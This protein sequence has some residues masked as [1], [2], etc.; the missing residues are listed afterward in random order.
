MAIVGKLKSEIENIIG[1]TYTETEVI[2]I[3]NECL[4][5][6]LVPVLRLETKS[7]TAI[8]DGD[9]TVS[10]P[11][12][13][14]KLVNVHMHNSDEYLREVY[15]NDDNSSGYKIFDSVLEVRQDAKKLPDLLTIW[16]YRYPAAIS[17]MTDTPDMPPQFHHALKYYFLGIKHD[18]PELQKFYLEKYMNMKTQI[19][20]A[21]RKRV[22]IGKSRRI[23]KTYW[24]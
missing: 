24:F 2:D 17:S 6:D 10:L 7:S 16:Y 20:E 14:Y 19:D 12:D 8:T 4:R 23:K 5:E 21:S 11:D 1:E 13:L 9:T 15:L 3:F 22:G 18:E